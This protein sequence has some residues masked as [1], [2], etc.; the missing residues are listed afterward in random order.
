[1]EIQPPFNRVGWCLRWSDIILTIMYYHVRQAVRLLFVIFFIIGFT[2]SHVFALSVW[3]D[4]FDTNLL[5]ETSSHVYKATSS[6]ILDKDGSVP[7]AYPF[8]AT[9]VFY[10]ENVVNGTNYNGFTFPQDTGTIELWVKGTFT[11]TG[12]DGIISNWS[13][14]NKQIFF[15]TYSLGGSGSNFQVAFTNPGQSYAFVSNGLVTDDEWNFVTITWDMNTAVADVYIN[16]TL[17][18][19]STISDA[20]WRPSTQSFILGSNFVGQISHARVLSKYVDS[21][22]VRSDYSSTVLPSGTLISKPITPSSISTWG[23]VSWSVDVPAQTGFNVQVEYEHS[24]NW[25]LIPDDVLL[26]NASGFSTPLVSLVSISTT[27]YPKIR[28][29]GNFSTSDTISTPELFDWQIDWT[30]SLGLHPRLYWNTT[31]INFLKAKIAANEEPYISHWLAIKNLADVYITETPPLPTDDIVASSTQEGPFRSIGNRLPFMAMAYQLTNDVKYLNGAVT[32]M[33]ALVSYPHWQGD[34]DLGAAHALYNM[35]IAYDWL[36]NDLTPVQRVSYETK[37]EYH[38]KAMYD[39][40]SGSTP[41]WQ[42]SAYNQNHNFVDMSAM[43]TAAVA[44]YDVMPG[45]DT[46]I[47]RAYDNF[48]TVLTGPYLQADGA[49]QEGISYWSYGME[50]LLRYFALETDVFEIDRSLLIPYIQNATL[51][52]LY[53]GMPNYW[54]TVEMG[55]TRSWDYYGPTFIMMRVASLFNDKLAQWLGEKLDAKRVEGGQVGIDSDWRTLLWYDESVEKQDVLTMPTYRLFPILGF[56]T[57]RSAWNDDNALMFAMKAGPPVGHNITDA[58][59]GHVHPDEGGFT[60]AQFGKK[61]VIEDGYMYSKLTSDHNVP[62]FD[63]VGQLGE[64]SPWFDGT[65]AISNNASATIIYN[66]LDDSKGYEYLIADLAHIYRPVLGIT[67]Y[68]RHFILLKKGTLVIVDEIESNVDHHIEWRLHLNYDSTFTMAGST[69]LSGTIDGSDVGLVIDD[70]S[71]ESH[72]YSIAK[73]VVHSAEPGY[74]DDFYSN[75][76]QLSTTTR[77]ARIETVLRPFKSATSSPLEYIRKDGYLLIRLSDSSYTAINTTSRKIF[78]NV[79]PNNIEGT[80]TPPTITSSGS[81]WLSYFYPDRAVSNQS[82]INNSTYTPRISTT[83]IQQQTQQQQSPPSAYTPPSSSEINQSSCFYY[84]SKD[85]VYHDNNDDV[86]MLQ[87]FLNSNPKTVVATHGSGSKGHE[88]SYYGRA[89][90]RAVMKYQSLH[91][92]EIGKKLP[93][94]AFLKNT[95]RVANEGCK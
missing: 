62:T 20:T 89:T 95:R 5:T 88:I 19:H 30:S 76:F 29:K 84:F 83:T 28:L 37:M 66:D 67:K 33:N 23:N 51:Y 47:H 50:A 75:T 16:G 34:T 49:S 56:F 92:K 3:Q 7:S 87:Q 53:A 70:I 59:S 40:M 65:D 36:Y 55:D 21:N 57:S 69:T 17:V 6:Y 78:M 9:E 82:T 31:K 22:Q 43:M 10:Q 8:D 71:Q 4:S 91:L 64:G 35:G 77:L 72:I 24:G 26:G 81:G 41:N 12:E 39:A 25:D 18:K 38:T 13:G 27:T 60:L 46:Y 14:V 74:T 90:Y 44:A 80:I 86:I 1:M 58:G 48:T 32:W 54:E 45:A 15:R 68:L 11:A 2:S 79:D 61:L 42:A 93:S 73:E 85:L 52:R 94:G 63:G